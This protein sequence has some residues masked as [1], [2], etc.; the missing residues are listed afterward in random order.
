MTSSPPAASGMASELVPSASPQPLL[1]IRPRSFPAA[2]SDTSVNELSFSPSRSPPRPPR[3]SGRG[4]LRF[5]PWPRLCPP[6]KDTKAQ[7]KNTSFLTT[8]S[9]LG[10]APRHRCFV[11]PLRVM[12]LHSN[13]DADEAAGF[14]DSRQPVHATARNT[15][16]SLL[17]TL[18]NQSLPTSRRLH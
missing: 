7:S 16:P 5:S 8:R 4:E 3:A 14:R 6:P 1:G 15:G 18:V 11:E 12:D 10:L 2:F 17:S 9:V 13:N